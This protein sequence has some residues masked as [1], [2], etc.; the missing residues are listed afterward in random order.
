M[1]EEGGLAAAGGAQHDDVGL[2]DFRLFFLV[3]VLHALVV[4]VDSHGQHLFGLV[5]VDDVL[6]Q[7]FLDLVGLVLVQDIR[8]LLRE[9][10][11][12]CLSGGHVVLVQEMI[13]VAYAAF[14][15]GKA[16][17]G[18]VNGHIVL[19]M[20]RHH[21]FAHAAAHLGGGSFFCHI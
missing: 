2:L 18:V 5:L 13:D 8:E 19:V 14:A 17:T 7:I 11:V 16:G 3:A 21:P 4:V 9:I 20:H 15:D 10:M 12:L 1:G 6:V